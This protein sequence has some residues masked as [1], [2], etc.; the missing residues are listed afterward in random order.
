VPQFYL[1]RILLLLGIFNV[2]CASEA[3]GQTRSN[4]PAGKSVLPVDAIDALL[5]GGSQKQ[6]ATTQTIPIT[7]QAF[8]NAL[9]ISV[10]PGATAE[11][12]VQLQIPVKV[13]VKKGDVLLAHFWM[14]CEESMTG[15]GFAGFVFELAKDDFAKAVE[16]R[17]DAGSAWRECFVPFT[18]RRDFAA[19]DAHVCFRL[20][21]DRQTI[22]LAGLEI[23]NFGDAVKIA[24]LPRTKISYT[25]READAAW[26]KDALARIEKIRKGDLT[27]HVTDVSGNPLA[28]ATVHATLKRHAFS[29]GS[30]VTVEQL[31]GTTADAKTYREIVEKHFNLAVFE[32]DMKWPA[33]YES[34]PERTD[35]AL[36]WL[37]ER[38]IKV[39]GHNLLWPSWQWLPPELRQYKNDPDELRR[40]AS[41]HVTRAVGHFRGKLF[42]W[43]V[44][45]EPYSNHDL[46]D[47]LGKEVM[48]DWFKLAREADPDCKLYLNDFGILDGPSTNEHRKHFYETIGWLKE[49][50]APID[51]V[52]IQSHF[53]SDLPPPTQL[54]AVLDQ[55]S[56]FGLPIESTEVSLNIEDRPLQADY[57][58][59]Y[60]IAFFSHP[61]V[62]GI[63]LWGF[64]E[65]RHWRPQA[66]LFNKDW[67]PRPAWKAWTDLVDRDWKTDVEVTTDQDGKATIRGFCGEYEVNATAG[68]KRATDKT[69]LPR[70]GATVKLVA[71]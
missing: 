7:G 52:G 68:G 27:I 13:A 38:D 4:L 29:F 58:R 39:R 36:A 63:M 8:Q 62:N 49:K 48:V 3:P 32:N 15:D 10:K 11:W 2:L 24:D 44:I 66:A 57:L 56:Q 5:L 51:G 53:G 55:L 46:M 23:T 20:G 69:N 65:G 19:G 26:R 42:Q 16:Q 45:N 47:L 34:I 43:D 50:G 64:W 14:R 35:R 31:L 21:Y 41:E 60:M 25:G 71:R 18:A 22:D 12:N 33:M 1:L 40:R 54:L 9:R 61:N 6:L 59:D 30:C 70:D 28:G 17:I 67:S 37:A